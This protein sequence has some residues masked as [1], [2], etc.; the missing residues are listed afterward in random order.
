M[1]GIGKSLFKAN[2]KVGGGA[3]T[4]PDAQAFITASGISGTNATAINQLVLDL[5]SANIWTKMKAIYPIVGGTAS[6]HKWNLKDPRDLDAAYRLSFSTGWTHSSTGILPTNA[7][8]NS[9]FDLSTLSLSPHI[10]YYSRTNANTNT[11]QI[12]IGVRGNN[13]NI[14]YLSAWYKSV[15][16][17]NVIAR[18]SSA[19]VLLDGGVTN[20]SLGLYQTN[21]ISNTAKLQ[22]NSSILDSK[23]DTVAN[24][25][26]FGVTIGAFNSQGTFQFYTNR[27]CAFAS[28]GD[29]LTDTEA[30]NFYT[31]VQNYN[32][33]L[34]RQV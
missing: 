32:T 16:L 14:T 12:D 29:G 20:N 8:A 5:K 13:L 23:T 17:N 30:A 4:D 27:Q 10:S 1:I 7:Y 9:F 26:T 19:S 15:S 25:N 3:S 24:P 18:N 33:T 6:S 22:K 11:D 34:N 2:V 28:I 31:A 21:K